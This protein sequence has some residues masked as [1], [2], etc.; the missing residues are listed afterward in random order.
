MRPVAGTRPRNS[1]SFDCQNTSKYFGIFK[2]PVL[3]RR[4]IHAQKTTNAEHLHVYMLIFSSFNFVELAADTM[5]QQA[6][7]VAGKQRYLSLRS[8]HLGRDCPEN[9]PV[10]TQT[11]QYR[12]AVVYVITKGTSG[13]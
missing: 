9:C 2:T 13:N 11:V 5:N 4:H 12:K 1:V 3:R 10:A 7:L 6:T 8:L